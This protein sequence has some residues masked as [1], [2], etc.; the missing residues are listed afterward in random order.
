MVGNEN[1]IQKHAD[2]LG[3]P[4]LH[5]LLACILTGRDW[6]TISSAGGIN[7]EFRSREETARI[8]E[9]LPDYLLDVVSILRRVP[10]V[11]LLLFKTNDLLRVV[12]E[13]L[14]LKRPPAY[15]LALMAEYCLATIRNDTVGDGGGVMNWLRAWSEYLWLW[16]ALKAYQTKIL[17]LNTTTVR[18]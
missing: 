10:R 18:R 1:E 12:E 7:K 6:Q 17:L 5:R 15:G 8:K 11:L 4:D 9:K 13:S 14:S 16:L 2:G 3:V